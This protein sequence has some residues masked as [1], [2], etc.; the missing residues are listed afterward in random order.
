MANSEHLVK[1]KEGVAAWN[2]WR[3]ASPGTLPDLSGVNVSGANLEGFNLV[4]TDLCGT[5]LTAANLRGVDVSGANV[6]GTTFQNVDLASAKGLDVVNHFGRS[7][8]SISTLYRSHGRIPESFLRGCRV[9]DDYIS[10][11]LPDKLAGQ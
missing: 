9:P 1:L 7:A 10:S 6:G 8:V 4:E 3:K 2:G 5:D 11:L